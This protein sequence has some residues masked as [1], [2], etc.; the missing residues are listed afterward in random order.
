MVITMRRTLLV[1]MLSI[2]MAATQSSGGAG[3]RAPATRGIHHIKRV[4][5]ISVDGMHALDVANYVKEHPESTLAKL[6]AHGV[7][8]TQAWTSRPSD[9]FPGTLAEFTGGSPI[10]TGHVVLPQLRPQ[11]FAAAFKMRHFGHG[12]DVRPDHGLQPA[13]SGRRRRTGSGQ[14]AVGPRTGMCPVYPHQY[15]RVNTIFEVAKAHGMRTAWT[16]KHPVYDVVNGPSGHGVDDLF[17]PEISA[18]PG[19]GKTYQSSVPLTEKYD[20]IKVQATLN[21]IAGMDHTGQHMV[22]VPAILG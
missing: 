6:S 20:D 12:R 11:A 17:N 7:T 4:L 8:Y 14:A 15:L 22:G 19:G 10:S 16:D 21:Q 3:G 2:L 9:S 5:F 13:C 1:A 18:D